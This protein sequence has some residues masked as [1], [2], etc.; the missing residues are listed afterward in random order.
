MLHGPPT[1]EFTTDDENELTEAEKS[2][3]AQDFLAYQEQVKKFIEKQMIENPLPTITNTDISDGDD[4]DDDDGL[5]TDR[6][7]VGRLDRS[8]TA[9]QLYAAFGRYGK[10]RW[11]RVFPAEV[12]RSGNTAHVCFEGT[13][14]V[15]RVMDDHRGPGFTIKGVRVSFKRSKPGQ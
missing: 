10:V 15:D 1:L 8:I 11:V 2:S 12:S 3:A 6:M 7:R 5:P 4:G 9:D 13:N 14:S